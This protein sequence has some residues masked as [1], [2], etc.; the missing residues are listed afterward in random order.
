MPKVSVIVPVYNIEKYVTH[1]VESLLAQT[2]HDFELLLVNDGSTDSSLDVLKEFEKKD[3][4]IQVL[5]KE[6]GGLSDA[7]NYGMKHA[8]GEYLQFI[9][10]DDF[11]EDT[12]LEKCVRKLDETSADMVVFDYNQYYVETNTKERISNSFEENKVYTLKEY[13]TL[14]T[15]MMNAAWNKMY[16]RSLFIDHHIEYPVGY[17]YE[18]LGTTYRLIP[19]CKG[20]V[21]I[22]EALVNYLQ[23]RPGNITQQFNNRVY[24]IFD[25]IQLLIDDYKALGIYETYYEELKFLGSVNIL[26]CLKKTRNIMDSELAKKFVEDSFDFIHKTWPEFPKCKYPIEREKYDWVYT[27]ESIL[28]MYLSYRKLKMKKE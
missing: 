16:R 27:H 13:P 11:V 2:F 24:H 22:K 17:Y 5:T 7:R 12:L 21:F 6:N 25:M 14:L 3:E 23:D 10:G 26:E 15:N 8:N 18:D 4:R 9:D 19:R 20:I 28:K 1:C